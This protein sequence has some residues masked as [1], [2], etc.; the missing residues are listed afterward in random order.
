MITL[1]CIKSFAQNE[2]KNW[3]FGTGTDGLV[4]TNN[5]PQKVSNKLS[6]VGFE[7]M[8][9]VNE[10]S[11]G[12]LLF[13][14]DGIQAVNKNHTTMVNG[15]GLTGHQSGAQCVQSCPLPGACS[16]KFYLFTNSAWD[17]TAGA[18]SYSIVDF[19]TN[20]LGVVTNKNTL[21]WNGPSSQG[22]CLVSKPNS[23]DY[24]LIT[25]SFPTAEYKVFSITASGIST[26][27]TFIFSI[28]GESYQMNFDKNTGKLIVTGFGNKHVTS[29]NFNSTTGVISNEVQLAPTFTGEA[30]ATR[31]S[32]DGSKLYAGI[33]TSVGGIPQ[34]YQYSFSNS[35]WT[36]M[37]TCCYAHDLKVTPDGKMY[38]INTYNNSQ[39]ISVINSPNLSAVGNACGYQNLTF[40]PSFNGEVRRFPEFVILPQPPIANT[41]IVSITGTSINIPVLL[42]DTDPQNDPFNLDVIVQNPTFG[43]AIISGNNVV[44][45]A[46]N[47]S[48][49]GI[50]DTLIYRIK[51]I[52]CDVDT[53]RVIINYQTCSTNA[54][55]NWLKAPTY[56]SNISIGDMD[57]VG[58]QLT[59]EAIFNDNSTLN[60]SSQFGKLVSKHTNAS[61]VN[62][63]LMP[64]T[65][66]I[67]TTN[68]YVNTPSVCP[69]IKDRIYHVAMVYNG[70]VLKFYRNGFLLSFIPWSGNL[71]NNDL[72]TTIA[73]GPNSPGSAFQQLGYV[74]EVR[75][76]NVARNQTELQTYMNTSLPNP[77]TQLGLKGYYTFDNLL[78]KQGNTAF[79][80]TLNGGATINATNPNCNFVAD[81]CN[82]VIPQETIIN[83][84]TPVLS[85]DP[86]KN[87]LT[88]GNASAYNVGDT[89][90]LIQMKGAVIDSSNTAAF[91]TITD[92]KSAGNYEYNYVKSKTGNQIELKNKIL[93]TYEIP[94]GKVQLIRVPYYQNYTTTST[95]T[96][97][98]WDGTIGGV[99]VF[100]VANTLTLNNDINVSGKG[101]K[102]GNS[103]NQFNTSLTCFIN[104]F[105][106]PA[107]TIN[108]AAKGESIYNIGNTKSHGKGSNANGGGGGTGHNSGGG[109]G[110]NGGL[111][112]FGGYQLI[113]CGSAPFD[114]RGIGGKILTYSN[115]A[116]KIFLGG[117]GG[118]GHTDNAGG[119]DMKGGNGGGIVIIGAN[120]L[121]AANFK[122]LSK[123]DSGQVCNNNTNNCHDGNGGG[124]AGGTILLS[125][126]NYVSNT[127]IE[128]IG[129][130]G[131][132]LVLFNGTNANQVGPGGGGSGG[133]TWLKSPTLPTNLIS[134]LNGGL[135][136]VIV[137]NAN[138]PWGATSGQTGQTL[139]N[140][141]LPIT[142]T[143]FKPNIDSVK[144]NAAN[145]TCSN[146][147]FNGLGYTNTNPITTW[148]WYFGDGATATGQNVSHNYTTTNTFTVKLVVTDI[149]GCKDSITRNITTNSIVVDAGIDK[150]FCGAQT[151]VPLI[152]TSASAG[153][154]TYAWTSV[155]ATTITNASSLTPSANVNT[156][157][158]FYINVTSSLGCSGIDSIKIII[159]PI[160]IIQTLNDIAICKG[161]SLQ[162]TTTLGLNTY[163]WSNGIYVS[164]S[165]ISNPIFTD[166]VP[167]TL[168][169]TGSNGLCSAKDTINISIKP[170]PIVKTIK[171]TLICSSQ[172]IDL[173]TTTGA[174]SYSWIPSTF[175]S[176]TTISNPTFNGNL[177]NTYYVTG[178]AV[179][180]CEAKDTVVISVNVP[181][182]FIDPP[183][184]S[185]CKNESVILDGFN[186]NNVTY[187]WQPPTN[188]S[189]TT[190]INPIANPTSTMPYNVNIVD[191]VCNYNKTFTVLVTVNPLPLITVTKSNDITCTN[192]TAKLNAS[193]AVGYVWN[194]S[195]TLSATNIAS[196]I[197][198]P[199]STSEYGVTG[200]DINGCKNNNKITV[201]VSQGNNS[202]V[203]PNTFTPNGDA[204]N[205]CFGIKNWGSTQNVYFI[206]YNRWGEKVFE[207]N[208]PNNCWNGKYKGE[209][210][211]EGNYVYYISAKTSCGDI[212][213]KGN[214]L[215]IR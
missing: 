50:S 141:N 108:A 117:G 80:G 33:A 160:P 13:Y 155:P 51:D 10:P 11:S 63:S 61:N 2:L 184:K 195:P 182:S 125:I 172:A 85:L 106:Y 62:Y 47:A 118:S 200:I 122:I 174:A 127:R 98:P 119:I 193:G 99:L 189:N 151:S 81:S 145:T 96:C 31:F 39:P 164:D 213:R 23:Y 22:M 48:A 34:L 194:P 147:N 59:V 142:T 202:F 56:P 204:K 21:F 128:A 121:D 70:S 167:R 138:N 183:N 37:N 133:I 180:G 181:N 191:P 20:P 78:N 169:V 168:I 175:L 161:T 12:N 1:F 170:L 55:D 163:Q 79:N 214:I 171:D 156:T 134:T 77:T 90:L 75:I 72:L 69:P 60:P 43:T 199:T 185:F 26:P 116:N 74:N 38:F 40:S 210:A 190:I 208:N 113:D 94:N 114:N 66:E 45:T 44:Y 9:V 159:N 205:E 139:F 84:Y 36:N 209:P 42:N 215:L 30:Y 83:N 6:G 129:G 123:G 68:G 197:A 25:N 144:I 28:T 115:A 86:C 166:T 131:A 111:G 95:L 135:S 87:I 97:L 57:I 24:W 89:V 5:I 82:V 8:I 14:S 100:N 157:T 65:C 103:L 19:T 18:L 188:L 152:G 35:T 120:S 49:C 187:S 179:N 211:G 140:L 146:Y 27:T 110:S 212:V 32:P 150:T 4:F 102:G 3:Y 132:D 53:A 143:T 67:T 54:C 158:T 101:F 178:T 173:T 176:S 192:T 136:G 206:I 112:G 130:K 196:P 177:G 76:W 186:G 137:Q 46:T 126:N 104:D 71:I 165:T 16:Q 201:L 109:G 91:G 149:N 198:T 41:D 88:V 7:G 52:N 148:Q 29:L 154:S 162:L 105:I 93:R 64:I 92:Y 15:S 73:S 107:G 124:G 203:L 17:Q 58:N 207:T 153:T